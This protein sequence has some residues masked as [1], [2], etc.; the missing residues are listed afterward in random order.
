MDQTK[1]EDPAYLLINWQ[2]RLSAKYE[3]R[4]DFAF[5]SHW[6]MWTRYFSITRAARELPSLTTD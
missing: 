2:S 5:T 6:T 3:V 1:G 4:M